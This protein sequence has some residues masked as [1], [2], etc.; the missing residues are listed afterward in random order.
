M[1]AIRH[2]TVTGISFM[3]PSRESGS[4][5]DD[6]VHSGGNDSSSLIGL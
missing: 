2:F 4:E 6:S 3:T 5:T 1:L